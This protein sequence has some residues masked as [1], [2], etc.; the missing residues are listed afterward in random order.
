MTGS[1][2][3]KQDKREANRRLRSRVR[4]AL[5]LGREVLPE[6]REVSNVWKMAKDGRQW[7]PPALTWKWRDR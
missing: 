4:D 5:K 3:E 2:S 6:L 1:P 7:W